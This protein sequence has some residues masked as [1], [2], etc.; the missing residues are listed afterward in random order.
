MSTDALPPSE[1]PDIDSL[2][3]DLFGLNIRGA[4][5]LGALFANPSSIFR[6]ARINDWQLKY[7]PTMRL[8]FSVL[9]VFSLLSFFWASE[10]GAMYQSLLHQVQNGANGD[11]DEVTAK[12]T[13]D[14][15]F[16]GYNFTYPFTYMILHSLIGAMIFIWG[17][18]TSWVARIRL[19]FAVVSVGLSL[20]VASIIFIPFIEPANIAIYT[21]VGTLVGFAAYIV[22]YVRGMSLMYSGVRLWGRGVLLALIITITDLAI[23]IIASLAGSIW[24]RMI[25]P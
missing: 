5:T 17:T 16:T 7:T 1:R 25:V 8:A 21:I 19:H 4:K 9:T 24:A 2:L 22:T 14:A 15:V 11:L 10:D 23:A 12:Q 20:A 3:S 13:I 6:S 18:G